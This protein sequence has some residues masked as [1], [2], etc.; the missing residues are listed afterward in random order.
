VRAIY[1]VFVDGLDFLPQ[2]FCERC[3]QRG[4]GIDVPRDFENAR[5]QRRKNCLDGSDDAVIE[6]VDSAGCLR[7][8]DAARDQQL[9]IPGLDLDVND[10]SV[11]HHIER[12]GERRNA[13][14]VCK[15]ELFEVCCRQLGDGLSR[16]S[17]WVSCVNYG[18]VVN[19][20]DAVQRRVHIELYPVRAQLDGALKCGK[21]V[22]GMC[23]VRAPVSDPLGRVVAL[24]C[25]QA[26]L[27]VVALCSMNAKL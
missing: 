4:A 5:P 7:F 2:V 14:P 22:L 26:F 17:L 3:E 21:G 1:K 11:A 13:R 20:D 15:W 6:G 27:R 18:I 10:C 16:G 25:R 12:F 24:T 19:D 23:L 9:D 8:A